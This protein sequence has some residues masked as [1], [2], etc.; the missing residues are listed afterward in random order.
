M[1]DQLPNNQGDIDNFVEAL[2]E[3]LQGSDI[4]M[5]QAV[6]DV[7]E[8]SSVTGGPQDAATTRA[9]LKTLVGELHWKKAQ[10]YFNHCL[11]EKKLQQHQDRYDEL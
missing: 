4:A 7:I 8:E 1:S 6:R 10:A 11:R 9:R 2:L 3:Y 5:Y